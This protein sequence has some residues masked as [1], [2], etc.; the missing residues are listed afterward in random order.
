MI[1]AVVLT[2]AL[3]G[4]LFVYGFPFVQGFSPLQKFT[5]SKIGMIAIT[6]VFLLVVV[7]VTSQVLKALK[8]HPT[9]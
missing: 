3:F 2:V 1:L 7:L 9:A 5:G 8:M 4:A 6:G